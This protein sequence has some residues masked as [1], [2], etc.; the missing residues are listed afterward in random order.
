MSLVSTA[1]SPIR[2]VQSA[3]G[4]RCSPAPR[5]RLIVPHPEHALRC[6]DHIPGAPAGHEGAR[7]GGVEEVDRQGIVQHA[8]HPR[9]RDRPAVRATIPKTNKRAKVAPDRRQRA[10]LLPVS[11]GRK[12]KEERAT[13]PATIATRGRKKA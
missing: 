5:R 3:Q 4:V 8:A 1:P 7:K 12:K 10:L 2:R 13:E 6:L 9:G 11:G